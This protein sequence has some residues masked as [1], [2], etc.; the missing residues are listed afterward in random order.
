MLSEYFSFLLLSQN[1]PELKMGEHEK[2]STHK[3]WTANF[4][5]NSGKS[6]SGL[7]IKCLKIKFKRHSTGSEAEAGPRGRGSKHGSFS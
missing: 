3:P 7:Y 5:T 4:K 2:Q 6:K 1:S